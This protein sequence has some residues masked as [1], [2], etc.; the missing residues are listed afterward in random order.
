[1]SLDDIDKLALDVFDLLADRGYMLD[2][3]QD[4][5]DLKHL[6]YDRLEQFCTRERNYN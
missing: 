2:E 4:W 3:N 1:M 6:L 5:E